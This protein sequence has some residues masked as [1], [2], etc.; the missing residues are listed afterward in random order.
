MEEVKQKDLTVPIELRAGSDA[1]SSSYKKDLKF[2]QSEQ[3]KVEADLAEL[4]SN[5]AL[6]SIR[7]ITASKITSLPQ[8]G[9]DKASLAK[10]QEAQDSESYITRMRRVSLAAKGAGTLNFAAKTPEELANYKIQLQKEA[11]ELIKLD[12]QHIQER[13]NLE[14]DRSKEA[15]EEIAKSTIETRDH[16]MLAAI[17]DSNTRQLKAFDLDSEKRLTSVKS[18]LEKQQKA[19]ADATKRGN[20]S[21]IEVQNKK[22]AIQELQGILK[23]G[24]QARINLIESMQT[25]ELMKDDDFNA[26]RLANAKKIG[27][28]LLKQAETEASATLNSL[29][30]QLKALE[31]SKATTVISEFYNTKRELVGKEIAA[32]KELIATLK[33]QYGL[34]KDIIGVHSESSSK[35]TDRLD[36]LITAIR[37]GE[38]RG[39][40]LTYDLYPTGIKGTGGQPASSAKGAMQVLDGT[41]SDM[42]EKHPEVASMAKESAGKARVLA[43][44]YLLKDLLEYY[45]DVDIA[46]AAYF[47]GS[48]MGTS[49]KIPVNA[50]FDK[51]GVKIGSTDQSELAKVVQILKGDTTARN[52]QSIAGYLKTFDKNYGKS[53]VSDSMLSADTAYGSKITEAENKL[54]SLEQTAKSVSAEM[55]T[56]NKEVEDGYAKINAEYTKLTG[57]MEEG[58]DAKATVRYAKEIENATLQVDKGTEAEK[59]RGQEVLAQI[60]VIESRTLAEQKYA[61]TLKEVNLIRSMNS[62]KLNQISALEQ[63][64]VKSPL[65]AMKERSAVKKNEMEQLSQEL[66]AM[67]ARNL[68]PGQAGYDE[69]VLRIQKIKN[70]LEQLAVTSNEVMNTVANSIGNAFETTFNGFLNGSIKAK[71]IFSEFSKSILKDLQAILIKEA[72]SAII[73]MVVKGIGGLLGG[74]LGGATGTFGSATATSIGMGG[75]GGSI[76]SSNGNIFSNGIVKQFSSGGIPDIGNQLQYFPMANGGTG[77]LRENGKFEAI[78]PLGRDSSGQLGIK[79]GVNNGGVSQQNVYNITVQVTDG[80]GGADPKGLG[81]QIAVSMMEKIADSRIAVANR[82]GNQLKPINSF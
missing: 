33:E 78:L 68:Q 75:G 56:A 38:A 11:D 70:E 44:E 20:S 69:A 6:S 3:K 54:K 55:R 80:S 37:G 57:T 42:M 36:S 34:Q 25:K 40:K 18:E 48:G 30:S 21:V 46:A 13:K 5:S 8:Y 60:T 73:N 9:L 64:G 53:A 72:K 65:D 29:D 19:L 31:D 58:I 7:N 79:G 43:G 50:A 49:G 71:N 28:E 24:E 51:A 82:L 62:E 76:A 66:T 39:G 77:S 81:Q 47:S 1:I 2:I 67:T 32:Q 12:A 52:G 41:Y 59:A 23:D 35:S 45:K 26:K 63:L 61:H 4:A 16:Y 10:Y 27:D 74:A 14:L 17:K 15:N 22:D